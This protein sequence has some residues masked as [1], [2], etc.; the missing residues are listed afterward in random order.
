MRNKF[1]EYKFTQRYGMEATGDMWQE[2]ATK[3][4]IEQERENFSQYVEECKAKGTYGQEYT[5]IMMVEQDPLFDK[6]SKK[7]TES[8]RMHFINFGDEK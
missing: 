3:E 5:T 7:Q 2:W 8:Y 6:P 4:E 1:T